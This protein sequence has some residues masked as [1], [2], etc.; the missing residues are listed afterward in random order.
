ML[1]RAQTVDVPYRAFARVVP[2]HNDIA[3]FHIA[4]LLASIDLVNFEKFVQI[5]QCTAHLESNEVSWRTQATHPL[6]GVVAF[7][8]SA[9]NL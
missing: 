9:V 4:E 3:R 5:V 6:G 2:T 8:A 1:Y 7:V